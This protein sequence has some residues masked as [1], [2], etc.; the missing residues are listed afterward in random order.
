MYMRFN[1]QFGEILHYTNGPKKNKTEKN[2]KIIIGP[3]HRVSQTVVEN[4]LQ[5]TYE[6]NLKID[7]YILINQ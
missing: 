4:Q 6:Y 2:L 1:I 7:L 3:I 5:T